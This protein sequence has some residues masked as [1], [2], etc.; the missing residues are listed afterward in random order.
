MLKRRAC[1]VSLSAL[2]RLSGSL[3]TVPALIGHGIEIA[4]PGRIIGPEPHEEPGLVPM[5]TT[6]GTGPATLIQR[7]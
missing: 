3:V 1:S 2:P 7:I 4:L 6:R 5:C